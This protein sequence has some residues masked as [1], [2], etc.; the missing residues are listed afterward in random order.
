MYSR[1]TTHE[2]PSSMWG[3]R[4]GDIPSSSPFLLPITWRSRG[5]A[6]GN[7]RTCVNSCNQELRL[8]CLCYCFVGQHD[9]TLQRI[10]YTKKAGR[11]PAQCK[12][13]AILAAEPH[14]KRPSLISPPSPLHISTAIGLLASTPVFAILSDKYQNRRVRTIKC[15]RV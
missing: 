2:S 1:N 5:I 6:R 7:V 4:E 10:N 9:A 15:D 11:S 14:A 3:R 8:L 13:H 12:Q